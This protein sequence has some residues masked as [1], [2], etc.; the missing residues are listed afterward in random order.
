MDGKGKH[1]GD[2]VLD[3]GDV[4]GEFNRRRFAE[5]ILKA[6]QRMLRR[7]ELDSDSD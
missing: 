3:A 2:E 4:E 5:H 7:C 6:E 1:E